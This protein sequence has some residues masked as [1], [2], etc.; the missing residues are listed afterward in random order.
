MRPHR[1]QTAKSARAAPPPARRGRVLAVK[2][3]YNP[4]S[5]SVGTDIPTFL[6]AAAGAGAL[7]TVVLTV[8][9]TAAARLR[10]DP[11]PGSGGRTPPDEPQD[12]PA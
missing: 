4:N 9:S 1:T 12:T 10:R 5:S 8:L 11:P 3:G 2:S 7:A 6:A